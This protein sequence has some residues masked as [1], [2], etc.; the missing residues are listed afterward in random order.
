MT[1][2]ASISN[3]Y[4][5]SSDA[6]DGN[7]TASLSSAEPSAERQASFMA[8]MAHVRVMMAANIAAEHKKQVVLH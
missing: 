1:Q 5:V 8:R 7:E 6:N 4:D 3:E 2:P